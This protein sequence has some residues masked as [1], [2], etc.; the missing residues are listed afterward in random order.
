VRVLVLVA[1]GTPPEPLSN[2]ESLLGVGLVLAS[3]LVA[4]A[5]AAF[6]SRMGARR[7]PLR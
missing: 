4:L 2:G 6:R 5:I 1:K 3:I 7:R